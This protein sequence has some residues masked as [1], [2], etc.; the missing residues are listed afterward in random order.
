MSS[1]IL[2]FL[3]LN[4]RT[5][6]DHASFAFYAGVPATYQKFKIDKLKYPGVSGYPTYHTGFE[7]FHLVDKII[8]PGFVTSRASTQISLHV[9]LQMS[10]SPLIP[11]SLQD[12]VTVLQ[13]GLEK[14]IFKTLRKLGVG[15]SLDVMIAAFLKF[16]SS[17]EAWQRETDRMKAGGLADKLK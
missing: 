7:T 9:I 2:F 1:Q 12:L 10:E 15:D 8:D 6:T 13:K 4:L 11:Y 17:I 16:K 14:D 3:F 5:G